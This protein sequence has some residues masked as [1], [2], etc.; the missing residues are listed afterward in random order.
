MWSGRGSLP[1]K[2]LRFSHISSATC[3]RKPPVAFQ[4]F[5]YCFGLVDRFHIF[6]DGGTVLLQ[7]LVQRL[8]YFMDDTTLDVSLRINGFHRFFETGKTIETAENPPLPVFRDIDDN[9]NHFVYYV[10]PEQFQIRPIEIKHGIPF[11]ERALLPGTDVIP[12]HVRNITDG[13]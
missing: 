1:S 10:V 3:H 9:V 13:A 4:L 11:L 12:H 5:R 8:P 6:T 7:E 2:I